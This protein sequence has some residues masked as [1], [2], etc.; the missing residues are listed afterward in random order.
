MY[1]LY[2]FGDTIENAF[3][4]FMGPLNGR[5]GFIGLY[6]L[7]II[8][9][10]LPT[11]AKHKNNPSFSS[12]GASG[13]VSAVVFAFI[14]VHPWAQL[15][16]FF[17]IPTPAII[18][19]ILYLVYSS[20]ASKNSNTIIDH[21]AHFY[22]ALFGILFTLLINKNFI[23]RFLNEIQNVPTLGEMFSF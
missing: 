7:G 21:D 1:V 12:V 20:W 3:V 16:L 6:I 17:I 13:A 19:G 22:G 2:I 23:T 15:L 10:S 14:L 18:F 5:L 9:S 8:F 4:T 11:H